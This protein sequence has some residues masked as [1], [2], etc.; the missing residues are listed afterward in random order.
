M[1][2]VR[3]RPFDHSPRSLLSF[4]FRLVVAFR[5]WARWLVVAFLCH[6]DSS[7]C[8]PIEGFAGLLSN[9]PCDVAPLQTASQSSQARHS[10]L[11]SKG[12]QDGTPPPWGSFVREAAWGIVYMGVIARRQHAKSIYPFVVD[13]LLE[14]LWGCPIK[15][16]S[17]FF[18]NKQIP[19]V[20]PSLTAKLLF[21]C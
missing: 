3:L 2:I 16:D 6:G 4:G 20:F 14:V 21:T 17:T 8:H 11:S 18:S 10:H 1:V 12:C 15:E 19:E 13:S 5:Q 7:P 9:P